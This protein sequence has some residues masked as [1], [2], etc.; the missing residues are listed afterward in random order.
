MVLT[1]RVSYN[2]L[3]KLVEDTL[4]KLKDF[5][6]IGITSETAA[7]WDTYRDIIRK[8]THEEMKVTMI[9]KSTCK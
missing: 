2:K 5:K 9:L 6:N 7:S 8:L 4:A 1:P 3:Q